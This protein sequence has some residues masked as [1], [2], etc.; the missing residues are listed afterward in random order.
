MTLIFFD[1]NVTI[2]NENTNGLKQ[3]VCL[4]VCNCFLF[5]LGE[6]YRNSQA[7][8]WIQCLGFL[9]R[10]STEKG[11]KCLQFTFMCILDIGDDARCTWEQ[12]K[13]DSN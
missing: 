2:L 4:N 6:G 3:I 9:V 5:S 8:F 10:T 12:Q 1:L 7:V 11:R 13:N